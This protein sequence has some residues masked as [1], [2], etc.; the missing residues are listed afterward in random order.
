MIVPA[1][2]DRKDLYVYLYHVD[3]PKRCSVG[4]SL[5][6]GE[7]VLSNDRALAASQVW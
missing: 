1:N 3:K 2:G 5:R 7:R 4:Y 6:A